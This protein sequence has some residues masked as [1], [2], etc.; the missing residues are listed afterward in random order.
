M[1][2]M[3]G[4]TM[5]MEEMKAA[6][7]THE[8]RAALKELGHFEL[9]R[10]WARAIPTGL[11]IFFRARKM[12]HKYPIAAYKQDIHTSLSTLRTAYNIRVVE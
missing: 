11:R 12:K 7:G 10:R 4:T 8:H 3:F 5:E 6:M 2:M 1:W 9:L